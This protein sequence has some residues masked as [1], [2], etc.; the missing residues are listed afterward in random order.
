MFFQ[1]AIKTKGEGIVCY[2]LCEAENKLSARLKVIERGLDLD[3][4]CGKT[5]EF[6]NPQAS[7]I[8]SKSTSGFIQYSPDDK[9]PFY[10]LGE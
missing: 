2:I 5:E 4:Y 9:N 7:E 1:T 3:D 6:T 8:F 10:H